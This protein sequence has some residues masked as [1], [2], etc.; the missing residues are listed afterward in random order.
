MRRTYNYTDNEIVEY[1]RSLGTTNIDSQSERQAIK[2]IME[3]FPDIEE[4]QLNNVLE[5]MSGK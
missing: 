2:D 3:A 1:L 4:H 5:I